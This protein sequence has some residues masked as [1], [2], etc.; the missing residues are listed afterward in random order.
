MVYCVS[1]SRPPPARK[2][3]AV[4]ASSSQRRPASRFRPRVYCSMYL[5]PLSYL[6]F[7][8]VR[9]LSCLFRLVV[10]V[11]F[12]FMLFHTLFGLPGL[13]TLRTSR[14]SRSPRT[15]LSTESTSLLISLTLSRQVRERGGWFLGGS[16]FWVPCVAHFV[17]VRQS[18]QCCR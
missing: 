11:C 3:Q 12:F 2:S 14:T 8:W 13:V 5:K 17:T 16:G 4:L 15:P 1:G 18:I 6:W 7:V 9:F 10:L